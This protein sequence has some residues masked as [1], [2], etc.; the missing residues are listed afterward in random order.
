MSYSLQEQFTRFISEKAFCNRKQ[1][2][3]LAVSGGVDSMVMCRLFHDAGFKFTMAHFNFGLRGKESDGDEAFVKKLAMAYGVPFFQTSADTKMLAKAKK[4]SIQMA[5]RELRYAWLEEIR[6][7]ENF[8]AIATA[9][10]LQDVTETMLINLLRGTG[11]HGMHGILPRNGNLIR[12]LLFASKTEIMEYAKATKLKWREDSS[13][14][15]TDYTRNL[16]RHKVLPVFEKINPSFEKTFG[17]N[18]QHFNDAANIVNQFI[19]NLESAIVHVKKDGE[20][21]FPKDFFLSHPAA[22]TILF[23]MLKK[24]DFT[25]SVVQDVIKSLSH[26]P[27]S[28]FYSASHQLLLDREFL[29]LSAVE[30]KSGETIMQEFKNHLEL[31]N[32]RFVLHIFPLA[33]SKKLYR[34][35]LNN[36]DKKVAYADVEKMK[37]PMA[38][39]TWKKGDVFYPFGMTGKKKLSD[40]FTDLRL[41]LTEK[42]RTFL[43]TDAEK[44]IWIMGHRMDKRVAITPETKFCYRLEFSPR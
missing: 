26:E 38:V 35:I 4:I 24:Y 22:G 1:T 3:L 2:I 32:E 6:E 43:L 16:L 37:L 34:I 25:T 8:H 23:E 31:V 9:H 41:S 10:H 7:R 30:T 19:E 18:A 29:I 27:G 11:I 40:F 14:N 15:K 36:M 44:I 13:N 42:E 17:Q 20:Q 12:P 33:M 21:W 28:R 5:A 39:R